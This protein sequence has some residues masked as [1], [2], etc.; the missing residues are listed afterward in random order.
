VLGQS[1]SSPDDRWGHSIELQCGLRRGQLQLNHLV[2]LLTDYT[3][4]SS[5]ESGDKV[6]RAGAYSAQAEAGNVKLVKGGWNKTYLDELEGFPEGQYKDQVD[7]SSRA[8]HRLARRIRHR[9]AVVLV[10][11]A[12]IPNP[13]NVSRASV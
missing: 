6:E 1:Q 4:H 10:G 7:A 13:R 11:P 8:F 3:V 12:T 9:E 5:T 2:Q